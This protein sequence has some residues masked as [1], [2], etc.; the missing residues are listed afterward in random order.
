[1]KQKSLPANKTT[2]PDSEIHYPWQSLHF[3][4]SATFTPHG[5]QIRELL[6]WITFSGWTLCRGR[7]RALP[8]LKALGRAWIWPWSH[9][10]QGTPEG[11]GVCG[12][13]SD[14]QAVLLFPGSCVQKR[15]WKCFPSRHFANP[16]PGGRQH[17][18]SNKQLP[19]EEKWAAW[20]LS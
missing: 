17:K 10:A 20:L 8:A 13:V 11:D 14:S 18:S 16:H 5:S 4:F 3:S 1:M 12:A 2:D 15:R 19:A 9:P 7:G 6:F